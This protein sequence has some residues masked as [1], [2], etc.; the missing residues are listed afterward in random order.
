MCGNPR[1]KNARTHEKLS[2]QERKEFQY[3]IIVMVQE[4]FD[5]TEEIDNEKY[6]GDDDEY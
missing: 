2:I 5:D 6:Y 4:Y 3:D 1:R